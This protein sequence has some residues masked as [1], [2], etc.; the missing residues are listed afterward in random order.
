MLGQRH[1]EHFTGGGW[2]ASRGG[3]RLPVINPATEQSMATVPE[4]TE[5]DI[6]SAVAAA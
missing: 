4:G 2:M 3:Q 6:D 1:I 5:E